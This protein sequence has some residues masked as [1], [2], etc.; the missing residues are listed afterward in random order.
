MIEQPLSS[1]MTENPYVLYIEK[2]LRKLGIQWHRTMLQLSSN[3]SSAH[4]PVVRSTFLL[5]KVE[6]AF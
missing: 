1:C 3:S 6:M 4:P 5:K 2:I